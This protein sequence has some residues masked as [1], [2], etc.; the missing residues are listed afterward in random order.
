MTMP[1]EEQKWRPRGVKGGL[2][3]IFSPRLVGNFRPGFLVS[4]TT[5]VTFSSAKPLG[6]LSPRLNR[7]RPLDRSSSLAGKASSL[8]LVL[9][10]PRTL[11]FSFHCSLRR[12][13]EIAVTL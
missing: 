12:L 8:T 2:E 1:T 10:G 9:L 11:P 5:A 6:S 13:Q 3:A 7:Q 4:P